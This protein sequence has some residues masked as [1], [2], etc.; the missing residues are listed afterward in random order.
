MKLIKPFIK[1]G[2]KPLALVIHK[3]INRLDKLSPNPKFYSILLNK[4]ELVLFDEYVSRSRGYLEFGMGGSTL[5]AL[6][7]S[8]AKIYSVESSLDWINHM[9]E[10]R[11]FRYMENKR[12]IIIRV[13]YGLTREWG[14]P[15]DSS[16]MKLFPAYSSYCFDFIHDEIIDT[17]LID[18]CF[19]VAC[20]LKSIIEC[21]SNKGLRILIHDFPNRPEWHVVLKH[22]TLTD[23]ADSLCVFKVKDD[24]DLSKLEKEY[25][26]YQYI[27]S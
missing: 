8:K 13:D 1:S 10:Y 9:R 21:R 22:L 3:I 14:M 20:A 5:Q 24:I 26:F 4:R 2:K 11:I 23:Q 6:K 12:L 25:E 19:R 16:S 18:G 27:P 7:I 15:A 17:I